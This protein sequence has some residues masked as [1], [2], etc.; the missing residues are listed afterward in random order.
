MLNVHVCC[1]FKFIIAFGLYKNKLT[2]RH[3]LHCMVL[4]YPRLLLLYIIFFFLFILHVIS[5]VYILWIFVYH[6]HSECTHIE[7]AIVPPP[8][9]LPFFL[10]FSFSNTFLLS[11]LTIYIQLLERCHR[12]HFLH[13][14]QHTKC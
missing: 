12:Q 9:L 13:L 14:I 1:W 7:I 6:F 8:L 4:Y 10:F 3:I 2:I 5:L 11:P